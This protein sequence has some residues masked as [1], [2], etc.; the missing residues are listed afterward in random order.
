MVQAKI[1]RCRRIVLERVHVSLV[2]TLFRSC[3]Y[4]HRLITIF[5][6]MVAELSALQQ[7]VTDLTGLDGLPVVIVQC[8]I[9][10][11]YTCVF[12]NF[13]LLY[14]TNML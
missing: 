14:P 12:K 4:N 2:S 13:P 3:S 8:V 11:I 7:I 1:W 10:T 9:T 6:Y 5:L